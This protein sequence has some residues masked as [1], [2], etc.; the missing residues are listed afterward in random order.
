MSRLEVRSLSRFD[1]DRATVIEEVSFGVEE[2]RICAIVGPPGCGSTSTLR[3]VAG[4]DRPDA[5]DVLLGER[6]LAPIP[7]HRRGIGMVTTDVALF[8]DLDVRRNVEFGLRMRRW[9]RGNRE[10]RAAAMLARFG[11]WPLAARRVD[12]LSPVERL[13][14][15]LARALAPQPALLLLDAPLAAI[16]EAHRAAVRTELA[17]A[18][19]AAETTTV[20]ATHDLRDAIA[21]ADDIVV[22]DEG[23][24]LQSGPLA[25]VLASPGSVRV[26][27]LVGYETLISGEVLDGRVVEEG[28]GAMRV[29][30]GFPLEHAAVVLA[31]PS[32]LLG[33]PPGLNLGSGVSGTVAAVHPQGPM[34]LLELE[35]GERR[36]EVRWEWDLRPPALG[37]QL[38]VVARP[39]T[40]RYFNAPWP[41]VPPTRAPEPE[42][43]P[44]AAEGEDDEEPEEAMSTPEPASD[45]EAGPPS[46][47]PPSA[48]PPSAAPP[49]A[50]PPSAAAP[51]AEP[52]S[53]EPPRETTADRDASPPA[54]AVPPAR[55]GEPAPER[56]Q[57]GTRVPPPSATPP[58]PRHPSMPTFD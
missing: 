28:V 17:D 24:V 9:P 54:S 18:L 5:G 12:T 43:E 2:G 52:P 30:D 10:Q 26:A 47:E 6:T 37:T 45:E 51:S 23:R 7:P 1:P 25:R 48:A 4:L 34:H 44:A 29:P 55:R 27:A 57:H 31:H 50:A 15:A 3:Q 8:P 22:M 53:A 46:T 32:T 35:V 42:P 16:D 33:V 49:S 40:L 13:R 21:I 39:G 20:V 56:G 41:P 14:V 36:L 19:R 38:E 11:L 58:S